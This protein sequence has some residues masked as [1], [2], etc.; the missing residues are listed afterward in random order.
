MSK[1]RKKMERKS[2]AKSRFWGAFGR[3]LAVIRGV[4]EEEYKALLWW[5]L[6]ERKR[7]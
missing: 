7:D 4:L 2:R 5:A 3:F 1:W 6:L